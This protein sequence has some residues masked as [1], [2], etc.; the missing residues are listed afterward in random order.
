MRED[1]WEALAS[2][3]NSNKRNDVPVREKK[4]QRGRE[5]EAV[6]PF[7]RD[8]SSHSSSSRV[9]TIQRNLREARRLKNQSVDSSPSSFFLFSPFLDSE[10]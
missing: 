9:I 5:R 8:W 10:A 4:K 3:R 1:G 7:F 2:R 6:S